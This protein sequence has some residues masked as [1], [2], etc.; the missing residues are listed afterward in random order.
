[1]DMKT[2]KIIL[3]SQSPRR[4]ELLAAMG[5]SFEVI[6]SDF[7]EKL[8]HGRTA[9]DV[10]IE[11][12]LGKALA[13]AEKYPEAIVIGSDT[14]VSLAGKQYGKSEDA[15]EQRAV[16]KELAGKK[17]EV[18]TSVVIICLAEK[19]Q[20]SAASVAQVLFKPWNE[21]DAVDYVALN[22]WRDKAAYSIQAGYK[23]I[24]HIVG[25][26]DVILGLPTDILA[27]QLRALGAEVHA[28][29][30]PCPVPVQKQ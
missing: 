1:M 4:K 19:L 14:I 26:Y 22:E 3:A 17:H 5:V 12:G 20:F 29:D 9:R 13:V 24:D 16:L 7:V 30:V 23:L 8:D 6:P 10:A 28:I 15:A 2:R 21:Q 27:K 11:L 18:V 25:R